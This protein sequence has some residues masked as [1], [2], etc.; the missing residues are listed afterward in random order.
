[1]DRLSTLRR[2]TRPRVHLILWS[3]VLLTIVVTVGAYRWLD[4][5]RAQRDRQALLD[6]GVPELNELGQRIR[7]HLDLLRATSAF[8][9]STDGVLDTDR[10][11]SFARP[12][13]DL[14]TSAY[15]VEWAPR[16]PLGDRTRFEADAAAHVQPGFRIV[17]PAVDSGWQPAPPRP[18]Y[19]PIL[20]QEPES[21]AVGLDVAFEAERKATIQ[22]AI[23]TG[24]PAA[25]SPF[26]L[27]E[28][29]SEDQYV[30]VYEPVESPPG[31]AI[32]VL[33]VS[34]LFRDWKAAFHDDRITPWV[35]GASTSLLL[36]RP[37]SDPDTHPELHWTESLSLGVGDVTVGL[38]VPW[39]Y[40]GG[41]DTV[42]WGTSAAGLLGLVLTALAL[43]LEQVR[44]L[45]LRVQR[46]Q[47]LGQYV[48]E[49]EL[50][51]GG[52]GVVFL[53]RHALM[54]RPTALKLML[55]QDRTNVERFEREVR[56]T[57]QLSHP[58]I[59]ALYDYGKTDDGLFYYAMEYLPGVDLA[60]LVAEIGPLPD[61]RAVYILQQLAMGLR[62]AHA[63]GLVHRDIKPG[64]M[65]LT[66]SGTQ[67]DQLKILDFGLVKPLSSPE[68]P[69]AHRLVGT[70][71]YMSPEAIADPAAA[72]PPTDI[73][74]LGCVAFSLLGGQP[75]LGTDAKDVNQILI[76]HTDRMPPLLSTKAFH[77]VTPR[78]EAVVDRCLSK[79][80]A[81]RP[82]AAELVE[83]M[84]T[85][86]VVAPWTQE[87]ASHWWGERKIGIPRAHLE[88]S[89]GLEVTVVRRRA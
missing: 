16:V 37:P 77:P 85:M 69:D 47:R 6:V 52:M 31:L 58:N 49:R 1:M 46:S 12:L 86:P 38:S 15:A 39:G 54:K 50:G 48:V 43:G 64:N 62:E 79:T 66:R 23:E 5:G 24:E 61:G 67:C 63:A 57:C 73:Y 53:A 22:R 27:A 18:V 10:F 71:L 59:I 76:S 75:P 36:G 7:S 70:P 3:G 26:A 82:T 21:T 29:T 89:T 41:A 33:N 32:V 78:L 20:Y 51:R 80:A 30:A 34:S 42:W 68:L 56:L 74:A 17:E 60:S 4:D 84:D 8:V 72:G 11:R 19:F 28:L 14:Q 45:R 2:E 87:E 35:K 13:L 81:E 44:V 25:S 40:G 9:T 88:P 65:M 83:I 55:S